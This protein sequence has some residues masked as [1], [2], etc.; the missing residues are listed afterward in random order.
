MVLGCHH[1]GLP[2]VPLVPHSRAPPL[3]LK[4]SCAVGGGSTRGGLRA[5]GA[6]TEDKSRQVGARSGTLGGTGPG[7]RQVLGRPE[8]PAGTDAPAV[9]LR[10]GARCQLT[11]NAVQGLRENK[12]LVL[13]SL[14]QSLR[15][16]GPT[17]D[18]QQARRLDHGGDIGLLSPGRLRAP[19][20]KEA[21]GKLDLVILP[22]AKGGL[23]ALRPV[24][25]EWGRRGRAPRSLGSGGA[26]RTRKRAIT[27]A[28]TPA[29]L[30]PRVSRPVITLLLQK[31]PAKALSQQR[32]G[33]RGC[34]DGNNVATRKNRLE[35]REIVRLRK[36]SRWLHSCG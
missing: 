15:R 1:G 10:P 13:R 34:P 24:R 32:L 28:H 2:R 22:V 16:G 3:R 19:G 17:E 9:S 25:G 33:G 20:G 18:R 21:E 23:P 8:P 31:R 27:R 14:S 5:V 12:P 29:G 35:L 26:D 30:D 4:P 11:A 7:L 36:T 6:A